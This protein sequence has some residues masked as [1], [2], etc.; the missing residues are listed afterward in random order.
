MKLLLENWQR[1]LQEQG[2]PKKKPCK[3]TKCS[4]GMKPVLRKDGCI[5]YCEE[6]TTPL[7][8]TGLKNQYPIKMLAF[9]DDN[10][11]LAYQNSFSKFIDN[12]WTL[13][14][15][16]DN[17]TEIHAFDDKKKKTK[18]TKKILIGIYAGPKEKTFMT[19]NKNL[20]KFYILKC[21]VGGPPT[22]CKSYLIRKPIK[23]RRNAKLFFKVLIRHLKK[24]ER[25]K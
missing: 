13:A 8:K 5:D 18:P 16:Y 12:M 10:D 1:F 25:T 4:K 15:K 20:L 11:S 23:V 6:I 19:K 17:F 14:Q 24:F 2:K 7:I 3:I 22:R 21:E 9:Y